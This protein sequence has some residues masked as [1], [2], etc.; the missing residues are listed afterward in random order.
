M[1]KAFVA[2]FDPTGDLGIWRT[3]RP[4]LG[5]VDLN[6]T[7]VKGALYSYLMNHAR[8]KE[9]PRDHLPCIGKCLFRTHDGKRGLCPSPA[10]VGDLVVILYGGQVPYLLRAVDGGGLFAFVGECYL[11]GFM[12]EEAFTNGGEIFQESTFDFV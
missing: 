6:S 2:V 12:S 3:A 1:D 5:T 11:D 4:A 9:Y 10:R 8:D 7:D